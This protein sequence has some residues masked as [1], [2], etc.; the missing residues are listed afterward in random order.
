MGTRGLQALGYPGGLGVQV[1]AR[2]PETRWA[3]KR[4]SHTRVPSHTTPRTRT[5]THVP[6][7][8]FAQPQDPTL[9]CML[10]THPHSHR[11]LT[12]T[13]LARS[14]AHSPTPHACTLTARSPA[15][16]HLHT[17]LHVHHTQSPVLHRPSLLP[18]WASS[19]D[20]P[21]GQPHG[22]PESL[23]RPRPSPRHARWGSQSGPLPSSADRGWGTRPGGAPGCGKGP[24]PTPS[25]RALECADHSP[26]L[27]PAQGPMGPAGGRS[28]QPGEAGP[29][30]GAQAQ[31][32]ED[33]GRLGRLPPLPPPH[34]SRDE[35]LGPWEPGGR[36]W[37]W[38]QK[39]LSWDPSEGP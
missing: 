23:G 33:P 30:W 13:T 20:S 31:P 27:I 37:G 8:L 34:L 15:T 35:S 39:P 7:H 10:T 29:G 2:P 16:T 21:A 28:G 32:P 5:G 1:R 4:Q 6:G 22:G 9:T 24:L 12:C 38:G 19:L 14:P 25:A 18:L 17:H 11:T 36:G 3:G 26:S